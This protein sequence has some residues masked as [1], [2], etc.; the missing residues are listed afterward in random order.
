MFS[1]QYQQQPIFRGGFVIKRDWFKYYPTGI[2]YRYKKIFITADTA[3][4]VKE[5]NDYSVFIVSG[6]TED[7]HLHVLDMVRGKWESPDLK[8]V[9]VDLFNKW[10]LQPETGLA[11][12]GLYVEDKASGIGLI[13]ELKRCGVPVIGL[14]ADKDKLTRIENVLSYI[15]SGMVL[16]PNGENYGFNP[17]LLAEC[18]AFSRDDSHMHDDICDSLAYAIQEG[19]AKTKVSILDFFINE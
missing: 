15:E 3:M 17:D 19:L 5:H 1:S 2:K 11:C 4:K 14:V 18:E 16:L 7:N 6:I 12:S 9:A 8:R 13:Q 10:K